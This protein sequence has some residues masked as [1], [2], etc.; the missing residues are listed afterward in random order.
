MRRLHPD[1]RD[2]VSVAEAYT[3]PTRRRSHGR[4][5][6]LMCMIASADGATSVDGRSGPLGGGGDRSVFATLRD[7]ADVV[8]VGAG[9]ARD[10]R[11]GPPRREGLRIAIVTRSLRLDWDGALMRSGRAIVVTSETAGPVPDGMPVVRAGDD[12]VDLALAVQHLGAL[13]AGVV[14][15]E[16]GPSLNGALVAAGLV[17]ELCL[18]V[19]PHLVAGTSA[20]VA[21]GAVSALTRVALAHVLEE[22]GWLFLRYV[23]QAS[24]SR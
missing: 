2:P 22:D 1:P 19:S 4:P 14:M 11:Y 20:R 8:L 10:E 3:D 23:A 9:T 24:G 12:D 5:W 13:G 6:V 21:H 17:D 7:L 18:T 16:G 15:A